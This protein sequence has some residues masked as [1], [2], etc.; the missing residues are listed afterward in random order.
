MSRP[1]SSTAPLS[2][3]VEARQQARDRRL[4]A[5]GLANERDGRARSQ[6]EAHAAQ[7]GRLVGRVRE[8]DLHVFDVAA[9]AADLDFARVLLPG[10]VQDLE[11]ARR[12][13]DATLHDGID[14]DQAFQRR[15][16]HA[17][18][19]TKPMNEGAFRSENDR[20][21]TAATPRITV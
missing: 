8:R 14:V 10:L 16:H 3:F 21:I 1:S 2:G 7:R 11:Q 19:V 15:E 12:R 4:A 18:A 9:R 6:L 5:A 13:G 20:Y 17:I